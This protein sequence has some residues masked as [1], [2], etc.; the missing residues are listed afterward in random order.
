M[1][2][3]NSAKFLGKQYTE[4]H[5]REKAVNSPIC[6]KMIIS[7]GEGGNQYSCWILWKKKKNLNIMVLTMNC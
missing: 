4:Q 2:I 1:Y 7:C 3:I 6:N 5:S